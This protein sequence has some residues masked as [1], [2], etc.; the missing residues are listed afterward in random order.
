[1]IKAIVFDCFGVLTTDTWRAFVDSLPKEINIQKARNLNRDYDAGFI[2]RQEFLDGVQSL[3][4]RHPRQVE[5]LLD[6]EISK[7]YELLDYIRELK[8]S[9]KIGLL[10]NVATNWIRDKFL[11]L[12]EQKLFDEMIFSFE[13]KMTKPDSQ[14]YRLTNQR[15]G[16]RPEESILVDDIER[17][18]E[19]A[20]TQ[21]MKAIVYK[22]I[23]QLKNDLSKALSI[24]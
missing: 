12:E 15:L 17:Y 16:V 22:N 19:A 21:D 24:S 11:T 6:N 20:R 5:E 14:I 13:V 4:G 2:T 8:H 3:T 18:C 7:N 1:M 10:S 9:Y 23:S